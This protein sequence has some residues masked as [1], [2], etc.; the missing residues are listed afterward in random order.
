M[1]GTAFA[2]DK[3]E[4]KTDKDKASYAIGMD[5]G[6]SLK[7]ND[8][9]VDAEVLSQAIKDVMGGKKT[10]MTVDEEHATLSTLQKGLQDKMQTKMKALG[11]KNKKDGEAFLAANKKKP[12]I[13]TLPSGLQYQV[14]T[15]GN[16]KSPKATDTVTV[17][18]KG[19]LLDGTEFD[20]SYKHGQAVTFP[21]NGVIKGWTE[22]LQLMKEGAKWKLFIP[23]ELA[24]GET[25]T[26]GGPIGPNATLIFEVELSKVNSKK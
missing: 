14:I 9:D 26:P 21:V 18:Y 16:G 24:Y 22:A 6:T 12:G 10:L 20:S 4:L 25:G 1:A 17:Q 5:M 15:E 19:T 8:I 23:S 3:T 11:E 7:K 13:K 2:A